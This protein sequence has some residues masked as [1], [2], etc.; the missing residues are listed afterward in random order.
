M[1]NLKAEYRTRSGWPVRA[2]QSFY[3]IVK[4]SAVGKQMI[5][6]QVK[7]K[8]AMNGNREDWVW[9]CWEDNGKHQFACAFEEYMHPLDLIEIRKPVVPQVELFR[10]EYVPNVVDKAENI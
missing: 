7:M 1:I 6:G 10:R 8:D 3:H 5:K 2:L 9:H 4:G